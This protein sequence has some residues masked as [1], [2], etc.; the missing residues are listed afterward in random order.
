MLY[1]DVSVGGQVVDAMLDIGAIH[2]FIDLQEA[3]QLGFKLSKGTSTIKVV[4]SQ[5]KSV[6]GIARGVVVKIG[7][8]LR[9]LDFT[10]VPMD[11]F[12]MVLGLALFCQTLAFSVPALSFLVILDNQKIQV[13]TLKG[14][15]KSNAS[16]ISVM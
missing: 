7:D 16:I 14:M 5:A 12:K 15:R 4:N 3:K 13:I 8:W 11:D 1:A 9:K 10:I 6:H 2:N